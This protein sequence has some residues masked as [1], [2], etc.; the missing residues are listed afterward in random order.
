[1]SSLYDSGLDKLNMCNLQVGSIVAYRLLPSHLPR[2][3]LK[4]W[5]GKVVKRYDTHIQV[6]MVEPGYEGLT[7]SVLISQVVGI[8]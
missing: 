4:V 5:R 2:N 8:G 6:E 1:M 7:E 3:P